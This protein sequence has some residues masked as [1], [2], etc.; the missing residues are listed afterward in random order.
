MG[1]LFKS[2]VFHLFTALAALPVVLTAAPVQAADTDPVRAGAEAITARFMARAK[3]CGETLPYTP[4]VV[5]DSRPTLIAFYY[6]DRSIHASRWSEMPPPIQGMM[7]AWAAQGTLGLTPE[8]QFAEVFNSLLV[9]HELG[10]FAASANGREKDQAFWDGEV[11]ANR[12][13]IAFWKGEPGGEAALM[14]RL[15]N[16]NAFLDALP[17]PVPEGQEPRAWFE[18]NYEALGNDPQAYGWYQGLFMR[19]ARAQ[20]AADDFCQLIAPL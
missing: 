1:K 4:G 12:V 14:A 8:G 11:Y 16:Y 17:N 18:A 13:A 2:G 5:V 6:G 19:E 7:A 15:D 20:A 10:H 9:P 3:D